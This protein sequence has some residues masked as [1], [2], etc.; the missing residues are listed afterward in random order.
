MKCLL[1]V[2]DELNDI[3]LIL[4]MLSGRFALIIATTLAEAIKQFSMGLAEAV[5]LD[6]GLPDSPKEKTVQTFKANFPNAPIVVMSGN[7]DP[8]F[9][10]QTILDNASGYIQKDFHCKDPCRFCREIDAAIEHHK[11]NQ[12]IRRATH[13]LAKKP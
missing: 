4:P 11:E 10:E 5:L 8:K 3:R 12:T 6:L 13:E 7:S 1:I 9:I 2:E